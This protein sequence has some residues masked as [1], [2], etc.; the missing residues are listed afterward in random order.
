MGVNYFS[1]S[2]PYAL[3]K[4]LDAPDFFHYGKHFILDGMIV[5]YPGE[6]I[7]VFSENITLQEQQVSPAMKFK[8]FAEGMIPVDGEAA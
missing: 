8:I 2:P 3:G 7:Q 5:E 1:S 4:F 6:V